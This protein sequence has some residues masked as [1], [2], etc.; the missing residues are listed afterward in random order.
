VEILSSNKR[1]YYEYA[2]SDKFIAG[3][4][5]IGT[6]VKSIK[7][8]KASIAEAYCHIINGEIFIKGM[9]ISEYKQI[10]YTNHQPLMV[11]KLLLNKKEIN[12]LAKAIKEKGLTIIPLAIMLSDTGFIKVEIGV[13][14]GKNTTNKKASIKEKDLKRE[15]DRAK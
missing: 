4:Q 3:I 5:L 10:K 2:I 14:K 8:L 12:K 6:E 1:A 7:E 9:H 15:L 13:G 11:R